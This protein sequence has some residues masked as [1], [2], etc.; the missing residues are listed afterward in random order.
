V[1]YIEK[2]GRREEEEVN[3]ITR[4][5]EAYRAHTKQNILVAI[6]DGPSFGS[7]G[8]RHHNN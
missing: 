7:P 3:N 5:G 2:K 6:G 1:S 8:T 4:K